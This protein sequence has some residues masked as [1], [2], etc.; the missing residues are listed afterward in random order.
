M[1]GGNSA[2]NSRTST[3]NYPA[4][5]APAVSQVPSQPDRSAKWGSPASE[6]LYAEHIRPDGGLA[7]P[8][9]H[10]QEGRIAVLPKATRVPAT[11]IKAVHVRRRALLAWSLRPGGASACPWW[12]GMK[13]F[14]RRPICLGYLSRFA[15]VLPGRGR[16]V[17][18]FLSPDKSVTFLGNIVL[19]LLSG[20][21]HKTSVICIN[22]RPSYP[23]Y[24]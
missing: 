3:P 8:S 17:D 12:D 24:E 7:R 21:W 15:D 20:K 18:V 13:K 1:F 4:S 11:H 14:H 9:S 5:S 10:L 19:C 16:F 6:A 22:S 2:A 23:H